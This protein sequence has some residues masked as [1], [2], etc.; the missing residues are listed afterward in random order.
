MSGGIP[1]VDQNGDI[2]V[3]TGNG[4]FGGNTTNGLDSNGFPL[5]G[6]YGDCFIR[7]TDDPTSSP[8]NQNINGWGLKV[9]DYFTPQNNANLD[10]RD[11]DFR[12]SGAPIILPGLRRK[13]VAPASPGRCGKGW[14]RSTCSTGITWASSIARR[15]TSCR[16]GAIPRPRESIVRTGRPPSSMA[17]P[18]GF[19]A[20]VASGALLPLIGNASF[21]T[22]GQYTSQATGFFGTLNG[23]VSISANGSTNG[24]AWTSN[25]ANTSQRKHFDATNLALQLW[26]ST[27]AGNRDQ[28]PCCTATKFTTP[29]IAEGARSLPTRKVQASGGALR[30]TFSAFGPPIPPTSVPAAPSGLTAVADVFNMVNL[31]WNDNSFNEDQ[32]DIERS[33]DA[34]AT[35]TQVGGRECQR[36]HLYRHRHSGHHHLSIPGPELITSIWG[37]RIPTI[38]MSSPS[39]RPTRPSPARGMVSRPLTTTIPAAII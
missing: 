5:D 19:R 6:N 31:S 22:N 12:S 9:A 11:A 14:Q 7:I 32:F 25:C 18:I 23:T 1:V 28:L 15:I 3:V 8:T 36:H 27:D 39:R 10:A 35:W 16:N 13:R 29:T 24:V 4:A 20:T 26:T 34:G 37:G 30:V 2:Y 38:P 17:R 33:D 21:P